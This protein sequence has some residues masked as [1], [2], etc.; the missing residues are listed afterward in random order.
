MERLHV[1]MDQLSNA[2]PRQGP[3]VQ[4]CEEEEVEREGPACRVL[5]AQDTRAGP[6]ANH[7][8]AGLWAYSSGRLES[9][10]RLSWEGRLREQRIRSRLG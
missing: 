7:S 10:R 4:V 1:D 3:G 6:Q 8:S 5:G 2:F 9:T